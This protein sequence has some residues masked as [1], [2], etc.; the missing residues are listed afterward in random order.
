[1]SKR[2]DILEATKTQLTTYLTWA[3]SIEWENIR[4]M[5]SDFGEHEIPRV[6]FYYLTTEYQQQQGRVQATAILNVEVCLKS[7]ETLVV[8]QR[9][10]FDKMDDV[11]LAFGKQA[12]LG[13]PGVI[14]VRLLSDEVDAHT[15]LPHFIG[16]LTFEVVYLTTY[17]GC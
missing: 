17:T 12:N 7:T 14:H 1:M 2:H 15:I 11:L 16:I 8:D 6:Q 4:I 9:D 10:L 3:K 13:V 5:S